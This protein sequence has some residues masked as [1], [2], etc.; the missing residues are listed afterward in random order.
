MSHQDLYAILPCDEFFAS[1]PIVIRLNWNSHE[2]RRVQLLKSRATAARRMQSAS[3]I[4][5]VISHGIVD[6][7]GVGTPEL[8]LIVS[9]ETTSPKLSTQ[10]TVKTFWMLP[11]A[12]P[13]QATATVLH[14]VTVFTAAKKW[15]S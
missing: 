14:G 1:A 5:A 11:F 13:M 10:S 4:D 6:G 2:L 9:D 7:S 12:G 15:M 3:A 8:I